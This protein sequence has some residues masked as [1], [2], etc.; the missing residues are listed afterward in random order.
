MVQALHKFK[1]IYFVFHL[2][3]TKISLTTTVLMVLCQGFV[4][5]SLSL[6]VCPSVSVSTTEKMFYNLEM[7][8]HEALRSP[9]PY[10]VTNPWTGE[11]HPKHHHPR[12]SKTTTFSPKGRA[13]NCDSFRAAPM[14]TS[15][16]FFFCFSH[17]Y[18]FLKSL[19]LLH[20]Q[21]QLV[22]ATA[23]QTQKSPWNLSCRNWNHRQV[24]EKLH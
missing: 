16:F 2:L 7:S 17:F 15:C 18:P 20:W 21:K 22:R 3:M 23:L 19:I 24:E 12:L 8:E 10:D 14:K 6:T 11:L 13:K 5:G 1:S 9:L 4:D